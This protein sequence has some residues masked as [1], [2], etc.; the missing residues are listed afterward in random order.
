[1]KVLITGA[2]GFVGRHILQTLMQFEHPDLQLVAATRHP[3]KLPEQYRGEMRVGDLRDADYLD[4]VLTGINII[5][6]AAGWHNYSQHENLSR[7]N[8]LDP[9]I[10]LINRASEWRVARFVNLSSIAVAPHQQRNH[11]DVSGKP[12]RGCSMNNCLIAVEDYLKTRINPQTSPNLSVINLRC[13]V[14]SGRDLNQGLLPLLLQRQ[15]LPLISG[16]YGHLPIT[17]GRDIGQ[18]FARAALHPQLTGYHSFNIVGADN[19]Q[20]QE[21]L[22]WLHQKLFSRHH[23]HNSLPAA[24]TIPAHRVLSQ[25]TQHRPQPT[26]SCAITQAL[27]NPI[28]SYAKAK[29]VL[30][31][32]PQFNWQSSLGDFVGDFLKREI[33]VMM[34]ERER[35]VLV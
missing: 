27:C 18:A 28:M 4:R 12:Q 8:Y 31:Y 5:C 9:T 30:G 16:Q 6:H 29:Q 20:Q 11:D 7:K 17:D 22:S 35:D 15:H 14:E 23:Q 32:Q 1:M 10:E 3:E 19:P 2:D 13:G 33:E 34:E 26:C 21:V 25:L 24:L